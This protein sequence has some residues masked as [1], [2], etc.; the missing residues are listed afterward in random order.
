MTGFRGNDWIKRMRVKAK[1]ALARIQLSN[2]TARL[3]S[4]SQSTGKQGLV[5]LNRNKFKL[6][7]SAASLSI[8]IG[9]SFAGHAYVKKNT[10]EIYHVYMDGKEIGTVNQVEIVEQY[11]LDQYEKLEDKYPGVH[12]VLNADELEYK[13]ERAFKATASNDE[14][15]TALKPLLK[16]TAIGTEI[17]VDGQL[18]AIVNSEDTAQ[19]IFDKIQDKYVPEQQKKGQVEILS[20]QKEELNAG[21]SRLDEVDFVQDIKT[22]SVEIDP[23]MIMDPDEV[24][25]KMETGDVAP[26]KYIVEEGDC[27][28][29]I[30]EKF[31]IEKQVIYDNNP[32]IVDDKIFVGDELDLTVLQPTLSVKTVETFVETH[33]IQYET[34][35]E[36]DDS[37]R[38]GQTKV[39]KPGQ[40]GL[41]RVTFQLTKINGMI[42]KEELIEE[43]VL[44]EPVAAIVKRGTKVVLGEGTGNFRWPV[45]G[46]KLTSGYGKRWGKMHKGIDL[47]SSNRTIMAADN[48]K[49]IYSGWKS[50][51]GYTVILDHLNGYT[52]LYGHMSKL[53]VEKGDTVEKGDKIGT[54]GSTGD[55]TGIHLHFEVEKNGVI[56]NPIKYLN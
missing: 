50:G 55:S 25:Q 4:Q 19:A 15:L 27:V 2:W 3:K 21:E 29:C 13:P 33:G 6:A 38:K 40:E 44:E 11:I 1:H 9:G 17:R 52:T 23:E 8:I 43:E 54:M 31:D 35:Y 18:V 37:M 22:P 42:R 41:K 12:M 46:A 24:L 10:F 47:A 32:W 51:Y 45:S 36:Q 49:V 39:I 26:V 14:T 5:W 56:Q 53:S 28:S 34:I 30:A 7:L 48:A 20:A 16:S